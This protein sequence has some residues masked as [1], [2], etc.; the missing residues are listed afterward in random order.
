MYIQLEHPGNIGLIEFRN[1]AN[2]FSCLAA[3][4]VTDK[5]REGT[6][7]TAKRKRNKSPIKL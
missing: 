5:K 1:S 6:T 3:S 4:V 2:R 7:Q